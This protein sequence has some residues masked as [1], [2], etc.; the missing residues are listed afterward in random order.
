[1]RV[2]DLLLEPSLQLR[3]QTP[4][5]KARL[6]REVSGCSPTELMDPTPYLDPDSLLLTSGIGMNF[7]EERT[8]DAFVERLADVPVSAIVFATG[9]AHRVLPPGL[10]TACATYDVPLLEVPSVVPPLQVDRHVESVMQAERLAVVNR[11]WTLADECARLANKGAEVV[12]LLA[13]VFDTVQTPLAVYDAYGTVIA[14]YPEIVSWAPGISKKPRAG[15]LNIPLPMGLNNPCHLAVRQPDNDTPLASLLGP[16]ASIIALQLNRSVVV[17]A[18]RHQ[19]IKLLVTVCEAWEEA[20]HT[21]VT[22]AFNTLGLDRRSETTLLVA[23]MSGEFASTSWQLRVALHDTFHTVRVTEFDGR[24]VAFAQLPR[25][26]FDTVA[27]RLLRIHARQPLVLKAPTT[28]LFELRLSVAHALDLVR[29]IERPQ[30]APE[31]GLSAVVTATAGR[32]AREAAHRFLAPLVEHDSKRS[33][34][35]LDTLSTY[36][37]HNAQPSRTC[38]ALFIHRNT[39]NYRLRQIENLLRVQLDTVDGQATSLFALRLAGLETH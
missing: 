3:L 24:L 4:S 7:S 37:R 30:L 12:T 38:D 5:T 13:A 33:S 20:T 29:H 22:K 9:M 26:D 21:D 34:Q 25:E 27:Q 11:G 39:L 15:V 35:L 19:E 18:S 23:D 10:V 17:D 8:W 32:G 28:S 31:L 2:V 36:L 14:Q 6:E 1:M 16:V